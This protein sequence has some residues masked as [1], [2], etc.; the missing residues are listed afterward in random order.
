VALGPISSLPSNDFKAALREGRTQ[1]GLWTGLCSPIATEIVAVAGFDWVVVDTEHAPN[2]LPDVLAQLHAMG[3]GS[4]EP[5]VRCAWNDAVIIKRF[6]DI[7]VRS[8][9]VPFVQTLDDANRAVGATRYPPLGNRGVS[10]APRAN[11]YGRVPDYHRTAHRE[12]CLL[13]QV[14]TRAGLHNLDDIAALEGIDGVFIGPSD[15]AADMGHLGNSQ[16]PEVQAAIA[17]A[18]RR[19]RSAGK[20]AGILTPDVDAATRYLDLG[21]VFVAVGSD[22]GVLAKGTAQLAAHFKQQ[23]VRS[24][25]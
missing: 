5:V 11:L 21:F 8:L 24:N 9:L 16:H 6:L 4:A 13:V 10:M 14:E 22:V 19:I 3:R 7:G 1:I 15:L 2:E 25:A 12:L 18:C 20:A 23:A 17:D